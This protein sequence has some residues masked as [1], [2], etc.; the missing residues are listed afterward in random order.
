MDIAGVGKGVIDVG[1]GDGGTKE[2]G[3][4]I[5]EEGTVTSGLAR[6]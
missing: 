2:I 1:G 5:S 4:T 6:A 3:G